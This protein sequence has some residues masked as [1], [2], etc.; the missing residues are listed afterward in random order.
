MSMISDWVI[1]E[2]FSYSSSPYGVCE[3]SEYQY[4]V[5]LSQ[6]KQVA[7]FINI[8]DMLFEV[9]QAEEDDTEIDKI[10][11]AKFVTALE[12]TGLRR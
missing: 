8:E 10:A 6:T 1:I 12:N 5:V 11:L 4:P 7:S 3:A 2:Q 9:F